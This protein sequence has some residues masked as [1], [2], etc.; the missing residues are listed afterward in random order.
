MADAASIMSDTTTIQS[1]ASM[2]GNSAF[3]NL[4]QARSIAAQAREAEGIPGDT[5]PQELANL[6]PFHLQYNSKT[7]ILEK[8]IV[9]QSQCTS[10][11]GKHGHW[12]VQLQ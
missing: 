9:K 12:L 11:I 5:V 2:A 1:S 7:Y 4:R 8:W 3:S 10:W 6:H